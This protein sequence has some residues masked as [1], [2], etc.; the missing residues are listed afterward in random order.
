MRF[1]V[2]MYKTYLKINRKNP[3]RYLPR[4]LTIDD[5]EQGL[6]YLREIV[7]PSNHFS[8]E[9]EKLQRI[10]NANRMSLP[11]LLEQVSPNCTDLLITCMYE[12]RNESCDK[13]FV[14]ILTSYGICCSFNNAVQ[15]KWQPAFTRSYFNI[16]M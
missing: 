10:L 5:F 13:L 3:Y 11:Q 12:G 8:D 16:Y 9:L 15:R 4:G 7:Y 1:Y 2:I 14:P 6:R